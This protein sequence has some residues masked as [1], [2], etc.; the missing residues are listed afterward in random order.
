MFPVPSRAGA[1]TLATALLSGG[2]TENEFIA[3]PFDNIAVVTGD[4]DFVESTLLRQEIA[5]QRYEGYICCA[6]YDPT[7]DPAGIAQKAESL[8]LAE[9]AEGQ[10]ELDTYDA[11]FVNSGARGLGDYEYN[12]IEDDDDFVKDPLVIDRVRAYVEDRGR[13]LV[14]SDWAYDLIEAV[15]PDKLELAGDDLA[16][17]AAQLGVGGQRV[18]AE[19]KGELLR[20]RLQAGAASLLYNYGNWSVVE[21]VGPDVTVHLSGDVNFRPDGG[22]GVSVIP[23]SPLLVSFAAGRGLVV[24]SSFHWDAQTAALS[25]EILLALIEGLD[26]GNAADQADEE[27]SDAQ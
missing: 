16:Y 8:F 19:V 1:F 9:N 6:S 7:I 17:D 13:V 4:F 24:Y 2:C 27:V 10:A 15:W 12:G 21:G 14:V 25:D 18:A 20:N 22:D 3:Q 26:P 11:V 5:Y 23:D